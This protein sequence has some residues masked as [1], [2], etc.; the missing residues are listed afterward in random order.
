VYEIASI[1][2]T[3]KFAENFKE[4]GIYLGFRMTR[5]C[6]LGSSLASQRLEIVDKT[7]PSNCRRS[8]TTYPLP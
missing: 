3:H 2:K 6:R 8:A 1:Y 5:N 4:L 7:V